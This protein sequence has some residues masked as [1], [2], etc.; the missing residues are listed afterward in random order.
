MAWNGCGVGETDSGC[1]T[2]NNPPEDGDLYVPGTCATMSGTNGSGQQGPTTTRCQSGYWQNACTAAGLPSD[3]NGG[4]G[5][6]PDRCGPT[7]A[8]CSINCLNDPENCVATVPGSM[9]A[10]GRCDGSPTNHEAGTD[11]LPSGS[12]TWAT[13]IVQI[14]SLENSDGSII[15]GW[16]YQTANQSIWWQT[17][18]ANAQWALDEFSAYLDKLPGV[19]T[20]AQNLI[21]ATTQAYP[22]TGQQWIN[23]QQGYANSGVKPH[24]CYAK[25]YAG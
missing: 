8:S 13:T 18:P 2:S 23:I 22:L 5:T 11:N 24:K 16:A 25:P 3:C 9:P 20:I 14:Y 17:N 1:G 19:D 21:T 10:K 15:Y 6:G 4:T 12:S 7:A